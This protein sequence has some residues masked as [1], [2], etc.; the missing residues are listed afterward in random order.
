MRGLLHRTLESCILGGLSLK[1]WGK[2][3]VASWSATDTGRL[4][5]VLLSCSFKHKWQV[6]NIPLNIP[7]YSLGP[8]KR[9]ANQSI[10]FYF[11]FNLVSM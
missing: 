8:L 4:G 6:T 2:E 10:C 1:L 7:P 9:R 11:L 5:P 3:A